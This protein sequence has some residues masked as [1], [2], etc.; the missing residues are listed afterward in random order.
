ML[1]KQPKGASLINCLYQTILCFKE[2][3]RC[4]YYFELFT[5]LCCKSGEPL[6]G[7]NDISQS[8]GLKYNEICH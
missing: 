2:R 8:S 5:Y 6:N 7:K 4:R 1:E 3:A